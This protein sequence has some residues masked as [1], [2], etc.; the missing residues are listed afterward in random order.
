MCIR[1]RESTGET[2]PEGSTDES[3]PD[4]SSTS[5]ETIPGDGN[6]GG[7]GHFSHGRGNSSKTVINA[8][9]VRLA[10]FPTSPETPDLEIIEEAS[11]MAALPKLGDMGT[12]EAL[13]GLLLSLAL[14]SATFLVY[15]K[16]GRSERI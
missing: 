15:R 5:A 13:T 8:P 11:T 1:D 6:G 12:A 2:K 14:A 9:D 3:K 7:W 4:E 10:S 16:A